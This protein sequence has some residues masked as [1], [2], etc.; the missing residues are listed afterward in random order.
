MRG[1]YMAII[2]WD[3]SLGIDRTMKKCIKIIVAISLVYIC[4]I[5]CSREF[6]IIKGI[7]IT[8][9][10]NCIIVGRLYCGVTQPKY[11]YI[12]FAP[13]ASFPIV[14]FHTPKTISICGSTSKTEINLKDYECIYW[15]DPI[16]LPSKT[17]EKFQTENPYLFAINLWWDFGTYFYII[18]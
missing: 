16:T 6:Y 11:N 15:E 4:Y 13:Y 3:I 18:V 5:C 12:K 14:T 1:L 9:F 2:Y 8:I 17:Y 10:D 7:P